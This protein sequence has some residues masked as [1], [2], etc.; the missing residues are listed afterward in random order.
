MVSKIHSD[1]VAIVTGA[2][3]GIGRGTALL[4]A[5]RGARVVVADVNAEGAEATRAAIVENGGEAMVALADVADEA[6][7]K[8]LVDTT[9]ATYGQVDVLVNNAG[10]I[11]SKSVDQTSP[12]E[13]NRVIGVNLTGSYLCAYYVLPHMLERGSGVIVNMASPHAFQTGKNIAAYAASKG[14]IVALTR[15]MALDYSRRGIR[16]NCVVPGAIETAMLRAD[17]QQGDSSEA[18]LKGWERD[19]PIGRLGQPED[20]AR[21]VSWLASPDAAFVHGAPIFADGGLLAQLIPQ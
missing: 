11:I 18:N 19:Q 13:W 15:Q 10:I 3:S 21:V 16:V 20:I 8:A 1:Q 17:I 9:L 4:L 5:E 7:V 14:A 12:S 2:G 6:A